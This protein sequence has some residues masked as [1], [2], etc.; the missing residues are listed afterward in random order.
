MKK[1][2]IQRN[3]TLDKYR[4]VVQEDGGPWEQYKYYSFHTHL[5]AIFA[6]YDEAQ[7]MYLKLVREEQIVLHNLLV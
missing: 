1:Y 4:I 7:L 3:E 5:P 2:K 6:Y